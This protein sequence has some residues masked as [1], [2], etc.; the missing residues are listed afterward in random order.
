MPEAYCETL[1]RGAALRRLELAFRSQ[2]R[3]RGKRAGGGEPAQV[4]GAWLP[5]V[6]GVHTQTKAGAG[7]AAKSPCLAG[8]QAPQ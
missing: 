1:K 7:A 6:M 3:A 5:H 4:P 2:V 8:A